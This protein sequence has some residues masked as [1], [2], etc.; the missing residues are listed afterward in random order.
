MIHNG[1][2]EKEE[3]LRYLEKSLEEREIQVTFIKIDRRWDDVRSE[4]RFASLMQRVG[5]ER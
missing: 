1:L 3:A 2:G 5:F 4:P